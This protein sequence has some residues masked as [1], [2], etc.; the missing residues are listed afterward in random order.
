[1]SEN[2]GEAS[3]SP[4]PKRK[5]PNYALLV[6]MLVRDGRPFRECA[7]AAGY[8]ES[9]ASLGLKKLL[10]STKPVAELYAKELGRVTGNVSLLKPLAIRRLHAEIADNSSSQGIKAIELAGRFKETDWWVRGAD[11]QIGVFQSFAGESPEID[12]NSTLDAYKDVK[13]EK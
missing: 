7:L 12:E 13:E 4:R 11:I 10:S 1:M 9:V 6:R 2:V 8:A 3:I 5:V